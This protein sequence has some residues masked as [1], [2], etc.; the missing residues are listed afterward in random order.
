MKV[1]EQDLPRLQ[2]RAFDCLRLLDFDDHLDAG[3]HLA[4]R[5]DDLRARLAIGIVVHADALSCIVLDDNVVAVRNRLPHAA[6][7]KAD[8]IFQDLDFLRNSDAHLDCSEM[9]P[10]DT[11]TH[12]GLSALVRR[13]QRRAESGRASCHHGRRKIGPRV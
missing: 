12:G 10:I 2:H 13:K 9:G 4:G 7:H 11:V 5:G 6:R 8:A 1:S 3:K